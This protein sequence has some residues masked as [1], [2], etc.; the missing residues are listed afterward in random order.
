MSKKYVHGYTERESRRLED[1]AT[2]LTE[3]LH[4]DTIF[5]NGGRVLE[6]GCGVGSQTITIASKNP[7]AIFTS[8][9]ISETSL[10]KARK[11]QINIH[12]SNLACPV[13]GHNSYDADASIEQRKKH[14][15]CILTI[16]HYG[17]ENLI[18]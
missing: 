5:E 13:L 9:D 2:T 6:A 16:R 15:A 11:N 8:I 14:Q 17:T 12:L 3:L 18:R 10:E 7:G 4:F 1:Q